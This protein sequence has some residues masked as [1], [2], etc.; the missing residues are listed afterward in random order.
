M[1]R[2]T[3]SLITLA[4][5]AACATTAVEPNPPTVSARDVDYQILRPDCPV[6]RV[7]FSQWA[8]KFFDYA[9]TADAA[10]P[11]PAPDEDR[12]LKRHIGAFCHAL[13]QLDIADGQ[14]TNTQIVVAR[15][16]TEKS[17]FKH[18]IS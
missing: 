10:F 8:N 1:T 3:L 9:R 17:Y 12:D 15:V 14:G 5:L 18:Q 6:Q 7:R 4:T 13:Q 16:V 2:I 11:C